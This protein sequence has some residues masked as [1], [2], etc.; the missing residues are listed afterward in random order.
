MSTINE[1]TSVGL[2]LKD[3]IIVI[4]LVVVNVIS[5]SGVYYTM[6]SDI[7][8]LKSEQCEVKETLKKNNLEVINYKL[9]QIMNTLEKLSK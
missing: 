4:S 8:V 2:K 1:K 7:E 5:V 3:F 9:D 6:K